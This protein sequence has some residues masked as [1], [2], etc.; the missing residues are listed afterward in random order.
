[1]RA[2]AGRGGGGCGTLPALFLHP[3]KAPPP[4]P[5]VHTP[6]PQPRPPLP[7]ARVC[8]R[9]R[10]HTPLRPALRLPRRN[11]PCIIVH[12]CLWQ[13]IRLWLLPCSAWSWTSCP[14]HLRPPPPSWHL[15]RAAASRVRAGVAPV[16][17]E[18]ADGAERGGWRASRGKHLGRQHQPGR[19][20]TTCR[21]ASLHPPCRLALPPVARPRQQPA[22]TLYPDPLSPHPPP[23]RRVPAPPPLL[24]MHAPQ[25]C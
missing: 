17:C 25:A 5:L 14:R 6:N 16:R 15:H 13:P 22:F 21:A 1:M 4:H 9:S 20:I 10:I 11:H 8:A 3:G 2:A 18:A 12:A 7:P 24:H 23:R 19:P